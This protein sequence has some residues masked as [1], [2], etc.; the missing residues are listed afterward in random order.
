MKVLIIGYGSIGKKH[1]SIIKKNFK[2]TKIYILSRRKIKVN[3]AVVLKSKE[4]IKKIKP[5]Y[6]I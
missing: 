4:E 1:F 2:I 6:I 3:G 5:N